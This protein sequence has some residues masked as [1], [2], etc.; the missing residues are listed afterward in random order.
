M[1]L[2]NKRPTDKIDNEEVREQIEEIQEGALGNVLSLENTPT[3]ASPQ[4]EA[5]ELGDDGTDLWI[6]VGDTLL[7]ITPTSRIDVT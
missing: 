4:I 6:R 2:T 3:A 7:Q 1:G 5:N